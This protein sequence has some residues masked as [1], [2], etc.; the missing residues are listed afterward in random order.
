M[1]QPKS[2]KFRLRQKRIPLERA[3]QEEQNGTNFSLVA[4]SS[5]KLRVLKEFASK[6]WTIVHGFWTEF[7]TIDFG[8]K[9]YC[10]EGHLKMSRMAQ[11]SAW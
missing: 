1:L 11:I 10:K 4:P 8:K 3:S 9:G 5:E 6:S 2:E 7:E